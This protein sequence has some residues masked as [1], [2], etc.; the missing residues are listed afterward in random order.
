MYTCTFDQIN[1]WKLPVTEVTINYFFPE[2]YL[3]YSDTVSSQITLLIWLNMADT[4]TS[5][6]I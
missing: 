4:I 3:T 2:N 1:P 5:E 6:V